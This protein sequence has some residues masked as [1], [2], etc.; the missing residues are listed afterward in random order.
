MNGEER[1]ELTPEEEAAMEGTWPDHALSR[2]VR[3]VCERTIAMMGPDDE[4][5]QV[6]LRLPK[7]LLYFATY[8][9]VFEQAKGGGDFWREVESGNLPLD[10]KLCRAHR[11]RFLEEALTEL[12]NE[13]L[14]GFATLGHPLLYPPEEE[15]RGN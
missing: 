14:E 15:G 8:R 1:S 7:G 9:A 11:R 3:A 5:A 12:L 10:D 4:T 6:T 2:E 13:E